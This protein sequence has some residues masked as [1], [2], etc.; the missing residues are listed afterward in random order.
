MST[1]VCQSEDAPLQAC[2]SIMC[3]YKKGVNNYGC[4]RSDGGWRTTSRSRHQIL[5]HIQTP[6]LKHLTKRLML[7]FL[8]PSV[9]T[10][11]STGVSGS[12]NNIVSIHR[13]LEASFMYY[14]FKCSNGFPVSLRPS[15]PCAEKEETPSQ[16]WF[17]ML[18]LIQPLNGTVGCPLAAV[19]LPPSSPCSPQAKP[20]WV[21]VKDHMTIGIPDPAGDWEWIRP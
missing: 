12:D 18:H 6:R 20:H 4:R 5:T 16:L 19:P 15:C 9:R 10:I 14:T 17:L 3:Y 8:R 7:L 13:T 2:H 21:H 1:D 11:N